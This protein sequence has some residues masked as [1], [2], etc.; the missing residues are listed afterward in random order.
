MAE[1]CR[2]RNETEVKEN[3]CAEYASHLLRLRPFFQ[4]LFKNES[5]GISLCNALSTV[6]FYKYINFHRVQ[7]LMKLAIDNGI[8]IEGKSLGP[9]VTRMLVW[10]SVADRQKNS[11][12]S[13]LLLYR[14]F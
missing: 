4:A 13:S 7:A 6:H 10:T 2:R 9:C 3:C 11:L 12:Q 8:Q 14:A 5:A 1:T